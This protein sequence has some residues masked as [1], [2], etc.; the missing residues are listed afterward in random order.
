MT[1]RDIEQL[2]FDDMTEAYLS[3]REE[4]LAVADAFRTWATAPRG[5]RRGAWAA[6]AAALELEEHAASVYRHRV[7]DAQAHMPVPNM[8]AA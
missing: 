1:R 4:S 8:A 7:L 3:W 2:A 5:E 6:Y